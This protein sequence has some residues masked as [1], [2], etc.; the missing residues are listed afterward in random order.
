MGLLLQDQ[1]RGRTWAGEVLYLSIF[2]AGVAK[3]LLK[4][5]RVFPLLLDHPQTPV[6]PVKAVRAEMSSA[7]TAL[8]GR[9]RSS[10][11]SAQQTTKSSQLEQWSV[12]RDNLLS[13][14]CPGI[15]AESRSGGDA[16]HVG[17]VSASPPTGWTGT[18][19]ETLPFP[20]LVLEGSKTT[21]GLAGELQAGSAAVFPT[22]GFLQASRCPLL[23]FIPCQFGAG[24]LLRSY[25]HILRLQRKRRSGEETPA[26]VF[27]ER[28][29]AI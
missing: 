1:K 17:G 19:G 28:K 3:Q 26:A 13:W 23:L 5:E 27:P 15:G 4:S 29:A 7:L 2:A 10:P 12:P 8:A 22:G 11:L 21:R 18:P 24:C 14:R 16:A 9:P 6:F 25:L 20:R